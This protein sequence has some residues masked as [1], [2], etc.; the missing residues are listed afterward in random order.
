MECLKT[1]RA[2]FSAKDRMSLACLSSLK[3]CGSQTLRV[4]SAW[5]S[6]ESTSRALQTVHDNSARRWLTGESTAGVGRV[7][8][9]ET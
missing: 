9:P 3:D 1:V 7:G 2:A 5:E 8:G 4:G 6:S